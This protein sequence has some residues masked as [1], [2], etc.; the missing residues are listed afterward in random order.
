MS[1]LTEPA[2]CAR[3]SSAQR[4]PLAEV[5]GLPGRR[6]CGGRASAL[7]APGA[8]GLRPSRGREPWAGGGCGEGLGGLAWAVA[9]GRV[10]LDPISRGGRAVDRRVPSLTF[11]GCPNSPTAPQPL[12]TPGEGGVRGMP[13]P[14]VPPRTTHSSRLHS[15]NRPFPRAFR[16]PKPPNSPGSTTGVVGDDAGNLELQDAARR[17]S[18]GSPSR[19]GGQAPAPGSSPGGPPADGCLGLPAHFPQLVPK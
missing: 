1:S 6:W 4:R 7:V 15:T 16:A 17:P 11:P 18:C 5:A 13:S 19:S 14:R 2:S 12:E 3:R 8:A 9:V 10:A